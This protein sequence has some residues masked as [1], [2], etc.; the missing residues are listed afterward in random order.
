M[1]LDLH[2]TARQ[3]D[4]MAGDIRAGEEARQ[5]RLGLA[6]RTLDRPLE[7]AG[8]AL[9]L[10]VFRERVKAAAAHRV[11]WLVGEP[12]PLPPLSPVRLPEDSPGR[13]RGKGGVGEDEMPDLAVAFPAPPLPTD[14]AALATDGSQIDLDRHGPAHCC[15]INIGGASIHY[16]AS[17]SAE[18][19]NEPRLFSKAE[20]L[21]FREPGDGI[22]E[23]SID[24]PL[25][26]MKRMA[27]ECLELARRL[28]AMDPTV[29][30]VALLDG[31]LVLWEL[32][33]ERYPDFV[34]EE[35]LDTGVLA[36]MDSIRR[37]STSRPLAFGSYISLPRAT[38][39]VNLL[40]IAHCPH[41]GLE[42]LGCDRIC[43]Q[44]G[45]G[46]KEC[47]AVALGLMDRDLFEEVLEPGE[48]S[49]VFRSQSRIVLN[50]YREHQ[51]AF[52]YLNN[53]AELGRVEVPCWV[54]GDP[55]VLDLLHAALLDQSAK[56]SGY[57]VALQEAHERAVV[58]MGDRR[59]FWAIVQGTLESKGIAT[60][61]S[62]K[63][64]SKRI[65]AV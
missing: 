45:K 51:I 57:P 29:P 10:A 50:S 3:I 28:E 24:G 30:T 11:T 8:T 65:R 4:A 9:P 53:G 46:R 21:V 48:R 55:A 49:A 5:R 6:L 43:G 37:V 26:G 42:T 64:K 17:P 13:T 38:E 41:E 1:A 59:A 54:A 31:S 15:V 18:L 2:K 33:G 19:F 36:A 34:K 25:L 56:G 7:R 44:G 23:Y 27:M 52:F 22:R 32:S 47:N 40:R 16:G 14:Y 58:T 39:V 20:E 35:V 62:L 63:A 12:S 60:R 61:G